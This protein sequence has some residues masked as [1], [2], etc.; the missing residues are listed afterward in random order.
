MKQERPALI[1]VMGTSGCGKSTVGLALAQALAI[2]FVDGDD[3]HPAANVAKMSAGHPLNDEDRIPWL[4]KIREDAILLTSREGL[5][6]L[7]T[8]HPGPDPSSTSEPIAPELSLALSRIQPPSLQARVEAKERGEERKRE[9]VVVACSALKK[10]YRDL[11]R[12]EETTL[13]VPPPVEKEIETEKHLHKE[14]ETFFVYLQGTR[15]LLLN[16]MQN[17]P[18]HF[19]KAE[20]LD[21]QLKT[22]Q[23]PHQT[24]EPR[25]VVVPLGQGEDGSEERGK[26]VVIGEVIEQIRPLIGE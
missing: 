7:D 4:H 12:G 24:D 6:A 20:M 11:L 1:I 23:E 19:M 2:P 3:L 13:K 18:G 15:P 21:S 25:V 9:G 16:R 5:T 8:P 17:R 10:E 14:I 22:L 26:E